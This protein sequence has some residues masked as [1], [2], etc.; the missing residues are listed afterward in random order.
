MCAAPVDSMRH[1]IR[2]QNGPFWGGSDASRTETRR[3]VFPPQKREKTVIPTVGDK[4]SPDAPLRAWGRVRLS[5]TQARYD[6]ESPACIPVPR[7]HP[8]PSGTSPK[9]PQNQELANPHDCLVSR[10]Y[11]Q[12]PQNPHAFRDSGDSAVSYIYIYK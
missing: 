5:R 1:P 11:P 3:C 10:K 7:G 6:A 9:Y 12:Y 8:R 4:S 2:P